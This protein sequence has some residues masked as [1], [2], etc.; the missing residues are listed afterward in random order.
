MPKPPA[1][2]HRAAGGN[3]ESRRL[4]S[5]AAWGE[6]ERLLLRRP[7]KRESDAAGQQRLRG[8]LGRLATVDDPLDDLRGEKGK[9]HQSADILLADAIAPGELDHRGGP[10]GQKIC[11]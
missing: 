9:P 4:S 10:P 3:L 5:S 2:L 11:K 8:E 1:G 6:A 7:T